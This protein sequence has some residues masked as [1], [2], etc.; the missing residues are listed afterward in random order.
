MDGYK[1][2]EQG[3]IN[4]Y[5]FQ[6]EVG[7]TYTLDGDLKWKKNGFHFC[8][9]PEDTLRYVDAWNNEIEI[10]SV[11]GSGELEKFNDEYYGFFDMY[12]SSIMTIKRIVPREEV[13]ETIL[14]SNNID[15]IKR[16][17]TLMKLSNNEINV[18]RDNY[19]ELNR[20]IN[21]YQNEEYILKR[22]REL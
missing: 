21:Y 17:I 16:Y 8:T 20:T 2:L 18:I 15:R 5:G 14:S 22:K 13:F 19:P 7:K 12:A 1:A 9:Y 3:L 10:V 4:R 6:Y 11:E